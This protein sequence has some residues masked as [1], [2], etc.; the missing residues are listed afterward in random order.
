MYFHNSYSFTLYYQFVSANLPLLSYISMICSNK[1]GYSQFSSNP[2][3]STSTPYFALNILSL[4]SLCLSKHCLTCF[5]LRVGWPVKP[6]LVTLA[7]GILS[8]CLS[9]PLS[10]SLSL[11][12]FVIPYNFVSSQWHIITKFYTC[13]I[14]LQ[15]K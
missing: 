6:S 10:L 14:G 7:K 2:C 5:M 13:V 9:V 11:C 12:F 8:V 3:S 4:L 15:N 1:P